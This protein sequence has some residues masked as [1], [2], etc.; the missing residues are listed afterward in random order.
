MPI[1][2]ITSPTSIQIDGIDSGSVADAITNRKEL[3]S[4]IQ[5]ALQDWWAQQQQTSASQA[6]VV[7]KSHFDEVAKLTAQLNPDLD[8]LYQAK[9]VEC[10][11]LTQDLATLRNP[12]KP[13]QDWQ[14]LAGMLMSSP[15]FAKVRNAADLS[16]TASNGYTDLGFTLLSTHSIDGFIRAIA[17]IRFAMKALTVGDFSPQEIAEINQVLKIAEFEIVLS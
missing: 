10:N 11:K 7:T 13:T 17:N 4:N 2:V 12:P 14:G 9:I 6:Q 1:I 8:R 16:I 15:L 5:I 3:A